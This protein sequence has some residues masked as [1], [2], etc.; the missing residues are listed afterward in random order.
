MMEVLIHLQ[1]KK[2]TRRDE[3]YSKEESDDQKQITAKPG[4]QALARLM[5]A[6]EQ[7]PQ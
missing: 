2:Q 1:G 6:I 4:L 3:E 7:T 5:Y